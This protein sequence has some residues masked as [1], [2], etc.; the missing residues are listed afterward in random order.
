MNNPAVPPKSEKTPNQPVLFGPGGRPGGGPGGGGPM[1]GRV[2]VQKP[3]NVKR[4]LSRLLRY[5]GK[6][7]TLLIM[8]LLIMLFVTALDLLGPVLQSGAIDAF[9]YSATSG[10]TVHFGSYQKTVTDAAGAVIGTQTVR[11]LSFYLAVMAAV[12]LINGA[13][14]Y[15]QGII[16]AKVSMATV[17]TMR[18]DLFAKI[19]TLPIQYTDTH[20]HGD[21]MSR[22]TNDV[23]NVSNAVSQ[24]IASL[25]SSVL[26]LVGAFSMM[27]YYNWIMTLIACVTIPLTILISTALAKFMRKYFV[28]R[29]QILGQING[30]IEETVTGYKTVI[31]YGK[32][33]ESISKFADASGELRGV[34]IKARVWGSIM[35]PLMN[36]LGNLQ[37]L[38]VA[39][40]GAY[41]ILNPTAGMRKLTIGN[42][43][44]ILQYSKRFTRPINE[45]AN[46]YASILTALA[47][48]ER[49][50]DILDSPGE[51]DEGRYPAEAS[52]VKGNIELKDVHF[53][54]VEG[55]PVLKGLNLSIKA[56]QKIAIV[57]ATGSGKTTIVNLLTRFYEVNSG[58][59][60]VDGVNIRDY[61]KD[62]L[63]RS[64]AIVLQ[65][66]V[67]FND[68]I[69]ANIKYGR[70]GATDAEMI[71]AAKAAR[72]D[73]FIDRMPEGYDSLLTESGGNLSQG[74]RQLLSIARAVLA[75]PK[76]LIL[77]EATSS[78]DTRTEMH[79]QEAMVA[80]M[81]DRT[82]LIIAH[83]LSTIRDADVI[84]VIKDGVVTESGSHEELLALGGEYHNLY[85]SQFAGI[86]T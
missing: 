52:A 59:I 21:I 3:K 7:R 26:T 51:I 69:R 66:T 78:V 74:Q 15:F 71:E 55:E 16:A 34:S 36:F 27:L 4:T 2:N 18:R 58:A 32:E 46:Q 77:D 24:S 23:E 63:R 10:L 75:D 31:A 73:T 82:S 38:L 84:V 48:A 20:Q 53:A 72:A 45:I 49:I 50:F 40:F 79:I 44:A 68:S 42:I 54:Y 81:K 11:G 1:A 65:D 9:A 28:R 12:F 64:T 86:A 62:T 70:P 83:R 25:F 41:F 85:N 43:Q 22:M 29:Q 60:T 39:A 80:L 67:L 76:I 8:L 13:L 6:S 47:G 35:G 30:R 57:G 33:E 37:Y 56:G 19:S 17:Y 5:I 14:N 61:P